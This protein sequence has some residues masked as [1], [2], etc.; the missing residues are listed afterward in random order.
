[1]RTLNSN[2]CCD[3]CGNYFDIKGLPA[4]NSSYKLFRKHSGKNR[5]DYENFSFIKTIKYNFVYPCR[6][7]DIA[8]VYILFAKE[9]LKCNMH[10]PNDRS[11][12]YSNNEFVI[13]QNGMIETHRFINLDLIYHLTIKNK[14]KLEDGTILSTC[15]I[16][17][18]IPTA[19]LEEFISVFNNLKKIDNKNP[20]IFTLYIALKK[21][22]V[23]DCNNMVPDIVIENSRCSNCERTIPIDE[24]GTHYFQSLDAKQFVGMVLGNT[25]KVIYTINFVSFAYID[26]V[27]NDFFYQCDGTSDILF[28]CEIV[29]MN[30]DNPVAVEN[31]RYKEFVE[32]Y[33]SKVGHKEFATQYFSDDIGDEQDLVTI[34]I[35]IGKKNVEK[36]TKVFD[37]LKRVKSSNSGYFT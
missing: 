15:T 30:N 13:V 27:F 21:P 6:G 12:L 2:N 34:Y 3:K 17:Q 8:N 37:T 19:K 28:D 4:K 1:M 24:C 10:F 11:I 18:A 22:K 16:K 26:A 14:T 36:F 9:E 23:K 25:I 33:L 5:K 29:A 35:E 31:F 7:K 20:D 32:L